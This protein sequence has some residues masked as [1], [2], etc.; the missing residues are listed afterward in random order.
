[1]L[2]TKIN[3]PTQD[4]KMTKSE[5]QQYHGFDDETMALLEY[6]VKQG[7]KIVRIYDNNA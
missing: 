2:K 7:C 5:F 3:N 4:G 6:Y 1:M